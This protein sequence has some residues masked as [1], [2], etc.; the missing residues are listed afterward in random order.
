MIMTKELLSK[1]KESVISIS[2]I[3]ILIIVLNFAAPSFSL[4]PNYNFNAGPVFTS[5]MISI[6]PLILGLALFNMGAEKSMGKIGELV[7]TSLTK[8]KS[9]VL[10]AIIALLLGTLITIAEPDLTVLSLQLMPAG[11]NWTLIV[12]AS[13]GV[14]VML[15]VAVI[16]VILQKSIKVWLVIAYG[17]V[18]ALGCM[19]NPDFFPVVFDAGG[20]TTSAI[21]SPFIISFGIGIAAVR[22]GKNSEDDS[23]G[24]AGLCSLGPLISVMIMGIILGNNEASMNGILDKIPEQVDGLLVTLDSF[25]EIGPF[26][27][28]N[29]ISALK[30]VAIS[31]SPIVVF[32][33]IYNFI[34][35]APAKTIYS[36]LIGIAYTFV[37]LV[38]FLLGANAGFIPVAA[39]LGQS[40]NDLPLALF[41]LFG[42]VV[43]NM[44][45]LAEPAVHVLADQVTEVTSGV[46]RKWQVFLV[47]CLAAGVSVVL[48]IIRIYFHIPIIMMVSTLYIIGFVFC[49][50]VPDLYVAIA[51]DSTGVATGTLSS[52]FLLPMFI[53][54]TNSLYVSKGIAGEELASYILSDGFGI[55]GMISTT[56]IIAIELLGL[57]GV[58]KSKLN[59]KRALESVKEV[60]DS[61]V[62]HLPSYQEVNHVQ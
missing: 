20:A 32:F 36:I 37:G 31:L 54:Y 23:F 35:K 55:I 58:I 56:P 42:F 62:I 3:I 16:R 25:G 41:I 38:I 57:M 45:I 33:F 49:F 9:L 17:L 22:G 8:K 34:L 10:L 21:S 27:L 24:Y 12:V 4:D 43:G 1:L 29:F 51:F 7:G 30:D 5:F 52:C 2:P 48:N 19:A 13:L 26:Y 18:F 61:Q 14:G 50:I 6:V 15:A 53:G 60:D 11:P 39:T 28:D 44:I 59:Y 46:I 40:F 47:L